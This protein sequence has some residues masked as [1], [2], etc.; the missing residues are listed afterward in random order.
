MRYNTL[1]QTRHAVSVLTIAGLLILLFGAGIAAA[2][3]P[4]AETA[5][6]IQPLVDVKWI[7]ANSCNDNVRVIDI[8]SDLDGGSRTDYLRGHIPCALYSNYL[9]AG[10][11]AEDKNKVP[12]QLPPVDKLEA[13]IGG[14]G[15][16]QDTHVVIV[17][18]GKKAL[19][20]GAAARMYWTFKVLGHD[21]VSILDGGLAAYTKDKKNPLAKGNEKPEAKTFKANLRDDLLVDKDD[22][23][24][25]IDAGTLLV[26][27]RPSDQYI[28]INR[29]PKAAR[30]GTIPGAKNL[31][32]NWQTENNGGSFRD[33]DTLKQLYALAEIPTEGDQ[34][35]FC[36]SGH[37]AALGWFAS[38]ELLGNDQAKV[39][40]GSMLE[41]SSDSSAPMEQKVTLQ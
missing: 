32:E 24:A 16:D 25:A 23:M 10:W 36:N 5:T 31:P 22:V 9:K 21:A 40:D 12:G 15:I 28:G 19:D 8:R 1:H 39:Y 37:W 17:P 30:N 14:L 11:R 13:L 2:T 26:D 29:H 38:H 7:K 34:I 18:A 35:N 41:W 27:N 20:M 33:V 3:S 6:D 4:P